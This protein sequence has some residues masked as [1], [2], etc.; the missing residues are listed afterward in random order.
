MIILE[1]LASLSCPEKNMVVRD[2]AEDC[3]TETCINRRTRILGS[4]ADAEIGGRFGVILS[5]AIITQ[6]CRSGGEITILHVRARM[7]S[8]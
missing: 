6:P 8:E 1:R 7:A 2:T 5:I 4:G 3:L